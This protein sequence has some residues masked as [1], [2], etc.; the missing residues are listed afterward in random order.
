MV[1]YVHLFPALAALLIGIT[2]LFMTKGTKLHMFLGG[3]WVILMAIVAIS[4]FWVRDLSI[5][6][7]SWIHILSAFTLFSLIMGVWAIRRGRVRMH[8]GFMI[9]T[10]IGLVGAGAGT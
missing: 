8:R 2:V 3:T 9:G 6:G 1:L 10:F 4:S 5:E 7:P